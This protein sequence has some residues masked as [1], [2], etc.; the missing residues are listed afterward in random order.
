MELVN[1]RG[2]AWI[3]YDEANQTLDVAYTSSGEYRYF[4]VE[5]EVYDWLARVKS[6]GRFLNRLV[7][8]KYRYE[9]L[10]QQPSHGVDLEKLLRDS[11]QP[12]SKDET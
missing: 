4:G 7:K 9:R 5:R 3:R 10:G 12:L 1:S 6:K 8:G 2:I 11:L